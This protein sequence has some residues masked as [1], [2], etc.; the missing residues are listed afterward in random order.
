[1]FFFKA[2]LKIVFE[3]LYLIKLALFFFKKGKSLP[4]Q[5]IMR[6]ILLQYANFRVGVDNIIDE[7]KRLNQKV[8][9]YSSDNIST[10]VLQ[11]MGYIDE[12]SKLPEPMDRPIVSNNTKNFTYDISNLL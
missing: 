3:R 9:E 8:V 5:I 7:I 12:L 10:N 4:P 1:M 11:H 2:F 6:S